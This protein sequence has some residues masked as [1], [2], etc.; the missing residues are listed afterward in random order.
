MLSF[1]FVTLVWPVVS[2]RVAEIVDNTITAE[3]H[4]K[5]FDHD[6]TE[7]NINTFDALPKPEGEV[8]K[9]VN[10]AVEHARASKEVAEETVKTL[11]AAMQQAVSEGTMV[12]LDGVITL[13]KAI[14]R[15]KHAQTLSDMTATYKGRVSQFFEAIDRFQ[16]SKDGMAA[17]REAAQ[18]EYEAEKAQQEALVAITEEAR[19]KAAEDMKAALKKVKE[20]N[21][22]KAQ[23]QNRQEIDAVGDLLQ[24][25]G[26]VQKTN[27]DIKE[28]D[29]KSEANIHPIIHEAT[30]SVREWAND[31]M[32]DVCDK[33]LKTTDA[34]VQAIVARIK[35][36]KQ[37]GSLCGKVVKEL[38]SIYGSKKRTE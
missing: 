21:R 7:V 8:S 20:I 1:L 4:G 33:Y 38:V 36:E 32:K 28:Q 17:E 29:P 31:E 35:A 9:G 13:N 12:S 14:D 3:D 27:R 6:V 22:K 11:S 26:D 25:F 15:S 16:L 19:Q 5:L 24:K 37:P 2:K 23:Q 30:G 18:A 34:A 10:A